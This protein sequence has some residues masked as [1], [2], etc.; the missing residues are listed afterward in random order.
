[1]VWLTC[2]EGLPLAEW[3]K[4]IG[5]P[6]DGL[7]NLCRDNL[8]ETPEHSFMTCKASKQAWTQFRLLRQAADLPGAFD[9]WLEILSGLRPPSTPVQQDDSIPED[10]SEVKMTIEKPWDILRL[11]IIWCIWCS[12]CAHDL[13]D[14]EFHLGTTLFRAWQLTVQAGMGAYRAMIRYMKPPLSERSQAK[15]ANFTKVWTHGQI[16]CR[17]ERGLKWQMAPHPI[18]LSRDLANSLRQCPTVP[19][20]DSQSQQSPTQSRSASLSSQERNA[21]LRAEAIGDELLRDIMDHIRADIEDE[22]EAEEGDSSTLPVTPGPRASPDEEEDDITLP[23][24]LQSEDDLRE[25]TRFWLN[26]LPS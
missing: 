26:N 20:D 21:A 16:F 14:Q 18:F 11:S 24:D 1:M 3:R 13:R 15:I 25:L 9:S 5:M 7:C 17:N 8:L 12:K 4:R 19:P 23:A 6:C 2:N 22:L 10:K